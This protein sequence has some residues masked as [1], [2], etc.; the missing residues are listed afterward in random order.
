MANR[1]GVLL[2]NLGTPEAPTEVALSAYLK[3]FLAD[4][5]VIDYPRWLWQPI[6]Q[7]MVLRSRPR[8]SAA[9]YANVW[10]AD[11]SPILHHTRQLAQAVQTQFDPGEAIVG[12]G[13]RYGQPSLRTALEALLA[14]RVGRLIVVPLYP[15]YSRTTTQTT[16]DEIMRIAAGLQPQVPFDWVADYHEYPAYIEGIAAS[17]VARQTALGPSERLLFSFHGI[18]KRYGWLGDPYG[19]QC[20][21]S[22]RLIA[23]RLGLKEGEWAVA[24]Q[25]RFGPEPWLQ[26]YTLQTLRRWAKDGVRSV[27][28]VCPGFSIDCLE[29][30]DEVNR[31]YRHQFLAAGGE[32]FDYV[33]ALNAGQPQVELIKQLI[34]S[35]LLN[36]LMY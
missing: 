7:H 17:V 14:G 12:Y 36:R 21:R 16:L 24:F 31:E 20:R 8:K 4:P 9:L 1:I 13:M 2:T 30:L 32:Q 28:V 22:A 35:N 19:D 27:R 5:R 6:L 23:E 3:E 10:T 34:R 15:Q 33:P 29:T 26:P 11:G 18:P 25:S